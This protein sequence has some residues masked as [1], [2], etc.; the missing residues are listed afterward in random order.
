VRIVFCGSGWFPIVDA[1]R[2]RLPAGAEID[3]RDP[4]R[5]LAQAVAGAQV[6]LP[7]NA[8]VDAAALAAA[9]E[10]VLVQQPAVG[11][12]GIDLEAARARGVPV[13]NVPAAN[14]DAV[15]EAAL[16]LILALA[17]RLPAARAAFAAARIGEPPGV[18]LR[19]KVL[20][21]VGLGQTGQRLAAAARGLGME[22]VAVG[23]RSTV[24]E[25]DALLARADFVSLHC[26][27]TPAT[28]GMIG[29]AAF[30]AM[31]PGAYLVN[32]ARGAIVDRAALEQ[33]LASGRLG[34][35][36]LDVYWDEPWDPADPLYA[37]DDVVA[38]P[39]IAGSTVESFARIADAVAG[40]IGRIMRGDVAGLANRVA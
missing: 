33:A 6:I 14:S 13:C 21:V 3:V 24:A 11:V 34:G 1:I 38:L 25:R 18:E 26:P 23:S 7:S 19:G 12:E 40:N 27:L 37:R 16:L 30:A 29:A 8:R 36:G 15:A 39:H 32:C 5:H 2:A 31:K 4:A 28:R 35:V 9:R 20:G 10:L 17:R 22:V